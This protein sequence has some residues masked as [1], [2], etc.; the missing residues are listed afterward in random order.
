M[1]EREPFFRRPIR[2]L[3]FERK[4]TNPYQHAIQLLE[5]GELANAIVILQGITQRSWCDYC[6]KEIE[7]NIIPAIQ[8][9]EV[10]RASR[11]IKGLQL[12]D[13]TIR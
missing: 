9:N 7:E 1:S 4:P 12:V 13:E 8:R 5:K 10:E 2:D 6:I 11:L 3:V